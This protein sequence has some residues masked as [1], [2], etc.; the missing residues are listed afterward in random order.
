MYSDHQGQL[1][2]DGV[3]ATELA[4]AYGTPLYVYSEKRIEKQLMDIQTAFLDKYPNTHAAY[5]CKAFCTIYMCKLLDKAGFWLDVVSG[6][7]LYTALRAG[8]PTERI[9]FNGNNKTTEELKLAI[10]NGIGRIVIDNPSE[11]YALETLC[12]SYKLKGGNSFK[13]IKVLFRITPNVSSDTH[14]YITTG[15]KDSKFGVPLEDDILFPLI[16]DALN[17]EVLEFLGFHY[18]VGSQLL[19]TRAHLQAL[20][21]ILPLLKV[22]KARFGEDVKDFNMGGGF[23]IQYT[24][25]DQPLKLSEFVD[26]IMERLEGYCLAHGLKRPH[27]SME[28]GRFVVGEAGMQLYSIGNI[29]HIP[30]VKTYVNVDGGMTDNLRPGLYS[31]NYEDV[32]ANKVLQPKS[33]LVDIG[34]KCCESTDII[35]KNLNCA[36]PETGD[37]LAVFATGAYGYAMASNYNKLP[38]PAVVVVKEG[39][40]KLIVKRQT[41]E[42]LLRNEIFE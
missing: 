17:S 33:S 38:I 40:H 14:E 34:G 3:I 5:A 7:E 22:T 23:G 1:T 31:A 27:V 9:E 11:L 8:F 19:D 35:I 41:Y 26:P 20:E 12:K 37:L 4:E 29:K 42:D 21:V 18:H 6:G 39:R 13:K 16:G 25:S 30:G 28:P 15:K 2:I 36:T 32:I 10:E 24:E